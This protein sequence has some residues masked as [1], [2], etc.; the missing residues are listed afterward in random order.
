VGEV[1]DWWIFSQS[2]RGKERKG[3]ERGEKG[4]RS[5]GLGT[6]RRKLMGSMI[7]VGCEYGYGY[8]PGYGH[9]KAGFLRGGVEVNSHC[10]SRSGG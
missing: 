2:R 6:R 3:K 10:L 7:M 9:V 8:R 1:G 5:A 4:R